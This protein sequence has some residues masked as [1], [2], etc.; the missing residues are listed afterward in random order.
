[1]MKR[2]MMKPIGVIKNLWALLR[3]LSGDDAYER[4]LA[5]WRETHQGDGQSD[6]PMDAK[7]F[8]RTRQ[9]EEWSGVKR[10]C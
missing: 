5:H 8:F 10:C 3:R 9:E 4:Y 7:T 1:M 2:K 6:A